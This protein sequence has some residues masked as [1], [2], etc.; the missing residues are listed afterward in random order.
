MFLIEKKVSGSVMLFTTIPFN[1]KM[2]MIDFKDIL[3]VK[4]YMYIL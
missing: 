2:P 1:E 3:Y 4:L